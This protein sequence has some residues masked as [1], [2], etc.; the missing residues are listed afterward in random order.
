VPSPR[1]RSTIDP[2][3]KAASPEQRVYRPVCAVHMR[4]SRSGRIRNQP[5]NGSNS[6]DSRSGV[7]RALG[8]YSRRGADRSSIG[9]KYARS[10]HVLTSQTAPHLRTRT[11]RFE[12]ERRANRRA[13]CDAVNRA[14]GGR[15]RD[16]ARRRGMFRDVFVL[17]SLRRDDDCAFLGCVGCE[18]ETPK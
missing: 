5:R 14:S 15:S 13:S 10:K 11:R 2:P 17:S 8:A 7:V 3:R 9:V 18:A 1:G 4:D 16:V 6:H 12:N